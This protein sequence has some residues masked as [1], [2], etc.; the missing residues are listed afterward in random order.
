MCCQFFRRKNKP[1]YHKIESFDGN[2]LTVANEV[3]SNPIFGT[4]NVSEYFSFKS[5]E[6]LCNRKSYPAKTM[7][8]KKLQNCSV[9][10]IKKKRKV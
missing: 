1:S 10:E 8:I 5:N 9:K 3:E 6:N 4:V 2:K 7:N